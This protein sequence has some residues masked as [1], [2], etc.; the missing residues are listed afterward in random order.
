MGKYLAIMI[1]ILFLMQI[2]RFIEYA[3]Y[4]KLVKKF[5]YENDKDFME[6]A[7]KIKKGEFSRGGE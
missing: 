5:N 7:E 6:L 3:I 1:T 4:I 2:I